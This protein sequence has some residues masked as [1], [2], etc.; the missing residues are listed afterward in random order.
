MNYVIMKASMNTSPCYEAKKCGEIVF[1]KR[2]KGRLAFWKKKQISQTQTKEIY[3]SLEEKQAY[4]INT[5][6][7]M[8]RKKKEIRGCTI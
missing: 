8:E 2:V 4:K 1:R 3:K 6:Q 7:F 5:K